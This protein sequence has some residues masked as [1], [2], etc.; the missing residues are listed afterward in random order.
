MDCSCDSVHTM[1]PDWNNRCSACRK[2]SIP[3]T[4]WERCTAWWCRK[5]GHTFSPEDWFMF[6]IQNT[7]INRESLSA[8][9]KCRVCKKVVYTLCKG[10]VTKTR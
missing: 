7:A 10:I 4:P 6:E 5:V 8:E 1:L 9:L 3:M 2:Q